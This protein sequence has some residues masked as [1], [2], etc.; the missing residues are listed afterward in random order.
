MEHRMKLNPEPFALIRSGIKTIELRLYDEKRQQIS[1]GDRIRFL[2]REDGTAL[3][4]EV[5]ALHRF[6]SFAELYEHLPLLKCGYTE[7][8]VGEARSEDMAQFYQKEE[9]MRYGVLGIEVK[10]I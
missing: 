8:T 6:D 5:V 1:V 2:H 3:W 10:L 9:E 7:E 4:V